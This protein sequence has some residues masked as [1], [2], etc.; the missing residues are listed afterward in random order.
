M[1]VEYIKAH[2]SQRWQVQALGRRRGTGKA[3][4]GFID[5]RQSLCHDLPRGRR[6]D[7]AA[8]LSSRKTAPAK[9]QDLLYGEKKTFFGATEEGG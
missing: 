7:G 8:I 6:S 5:R 1:P 2:P 4:A 3:A 9:H